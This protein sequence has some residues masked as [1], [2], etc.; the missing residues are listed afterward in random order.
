MAEKPTP[1]Q[2]ELEVLQYVTAHPACSVGDVADEFARTRKL[3]RTT[4][5]TMMERLRKKGYLT[6]TKAGGVFQYSAK[7]AQGRTMTR[8][9]GRFVEKTLGGSLQ[10]FVAYFSGKAKV[11]KEELAELRELVEK[12]D[13]KDKKE[14]R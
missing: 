6:R 8:L 10:P 7:E 2:A 12:L 3:A 1:S 14:S 9:I 5:G 13:A 11:S 4:V